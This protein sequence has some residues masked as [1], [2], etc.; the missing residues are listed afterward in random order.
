MSAG[1]Y[2]SPAR[3]PLLIIKAFDLRPQ[4]EFLIVVQ[5]HTRPRST[6]SLDATNVIALE[7]RILYYSYSLEIT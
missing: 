3:P 1:D 5:C 6:R 4:S 7:Q 2:R